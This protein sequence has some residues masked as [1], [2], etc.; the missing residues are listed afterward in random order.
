MA[1]TIGR[2][3]PGPRDLP[4]DEHGAQPLGHWLTDGVIYCVLRAPGQEAFCRHHAEHGLPCDDAHP[5]AD[6]RGSHPF[7]PEET[8][9]VRAG[10]AEVWP[11]DGVAA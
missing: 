9:I 1:L 11:T 2:A 8:Q 4:I 6:L 10:I 7:S 3:C 5:L